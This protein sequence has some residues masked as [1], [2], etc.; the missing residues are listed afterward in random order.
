MGAG[1][2]LCRPLPLLEVKS[3]GG[4]SKGVAVVVE[5]RGLNADPGGSSGPPIS[6]STKGMVVKTELLLWL[7]GHGPN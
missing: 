6:K 5:S 2:G 7:S 1:G 3:M 4:K